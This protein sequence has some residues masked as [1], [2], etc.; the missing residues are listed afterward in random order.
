[1]LDLLKNCYMSTLGKLK[2]EIR[3]TAIYF[4]AAMA[5]RYVEELL[6]FWRRAGSFP[7]ANRRLFDE[8]IWPHFWGVNP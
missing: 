8:L 7:E 3:E 6:H 2:H 4:A 1:M 5:F